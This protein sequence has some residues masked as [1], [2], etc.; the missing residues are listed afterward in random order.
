MNTPAQTLGQGISFP[1]R[2]GPNGQIAWSSGADNV[3]ECIQVILLTEQQERVMLPEFGGGLRT[4]LFEP[5]NTSTQAAIRDRI[6]QALKDWEP[7]IAVDSVVV[8]PDGADPQSAVAMINYH[9]VATG[10]QGQVGVTVTLG[11]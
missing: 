8:T 7:R 5:N 10:A 4:F 3:R 11:S 9:L 1:P 2:I 6:A